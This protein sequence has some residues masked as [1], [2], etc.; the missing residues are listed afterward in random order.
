M[1]EVEEERR[2]GG[3]SEG[4]RVGTGDSFVGQDGQGTMPLAGGWART[5]AQWTESP[6]R[7]SM[8]ARMDMH[9]RWTEEAGDERQKRTTVH[10][11]VRLC[12]RTAPFTC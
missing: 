3:G 7:P 10:G 12:K 5:V 2:R 8:G 11:T 4:S 9:A 6:R 1:V